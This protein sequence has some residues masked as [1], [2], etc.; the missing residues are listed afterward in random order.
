MAEAFI[1]VLQR[2]IR[3]CL[4][5]KDL[6]EA[7]RL[8]GLLREEDPLSVETRGLDLE[9]LLGANRW[10]E[11][12]PLARQL[13]EF[14][15]ASA[16]ILHLA[17]RLAYRLKKYTEAANHLRES[18]RIHPHWFT[19]LF[20]GK[21]LT[22]QGI[23]DEAEAILRGLVDE[24]P[25]A[26]MDLSWLYERQG[27]F[28]RAL[29]EVD[30]FLAIFPDDCFAKSQQQRLRALRLQ[31]EEIIEE[32]DCL[33][34][35][36]EDFDPNLLPQFIDGLLRAGQAERARELI[37]QNDRNVEQHIATKIGWN[38]YKLQAYDLAFHLF[39]ITFPHQAGNV[40]FLSALERA[41]ER[42]G[43]LSEVT[44]LYRKH[45]KE[46]PR[47]FGRLRRLKKRE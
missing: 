26:R 21:T 24:R 4:R 35:H 38:C 28:S 17:G 43:K 33:R 30:T 6:P 44:D 36:G 8:I 11:A 31:P 13:V 7:I 45:A 29:R 20:L 34:A 16:R 42:C 2:N 10:E 39:V 14:F 27:E 41:G 23:F 12:E 25:S 15:P 1:R 40:K 19:A 3:T 9:Y 46:Q 32:M 47:L 22:Q 18:Q 37:L 5:N